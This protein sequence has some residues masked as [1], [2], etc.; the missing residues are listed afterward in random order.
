[1]ILNRTSARSNDD[2]PTK[3]M[4]GTNIST[5]RITQQRNKTCLRIRNKRKVW[6]QMQTCALTQIV[7]I[8]YLE[9]LK[10]LLSS[11]FALRAR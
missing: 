9:R 7:D 5:K 4:F 10:W 6:T 8:D 11:S 3:T 2:S 1:M